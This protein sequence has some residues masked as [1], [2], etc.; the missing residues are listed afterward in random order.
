MK[1]INISM[2]VLALCLLVAGPA[3]AR[4]CGEYSKI[5]ETEATCSGTVYQRMSKYDRNEWEIFFGDRL[6]QEYD[7]ARDAAE[8]AEECRGGLEKE[9]DFCQEDYDEEYEDCKEE[10]DEEMEDCQEGFEK[11]LDEFIKTQHRERAAW[12]NKEDLCKIR[13]TKKCVDA[14]VAYNNIA[15][16][17]EA[18]NKALNNN[19][20]TCKS[21]AESGFNECVEGPESQLK[22]CEE[23]ANKDVDA[24]ESDAKKACKKVKKAFVNALRS[25]KSKDKAKGSFRC[26]PSGWESKKPNPGP[27]WMCNLLG[28]NETDRTC[29]EPTIYPH[30]L[31]EED[32]ENGRG[33]RIRNCAV[34]NGAMYRIRVNGKAKWE[35]YRDVKCVR[36]PLAAPE[37][38]ITPTVTPTATSTP[39]AGGSGGGVVTPTP[40]ATATAPV[41]SCGVNQRSC[42][43][44]SDCPAGGPVNG[45]RGVRQEFQCKSGCCEY[46]LTE[47]KDPQDIFDARDFSV[48]PR[49]PVT[50]F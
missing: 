44:N 32:D 20:A 19:L 1:K 50:I 6:V 46:T 38:G 16:E 15:A 40:T 29:D 37:P 42:E 48:T 7:R 12:Y 36:S 28:F 43:T 23:E 9:L 2:Y 8:E 33:K 5:I 10:L 18:Q 3:F 49:L 35:C 30:D 45:R 25:D 31:P 14:K 4:D 47:T 27:E 34:H 11:D 17:L 22:E 13:V 26:T 39:I 21:Q 41:R 24:C